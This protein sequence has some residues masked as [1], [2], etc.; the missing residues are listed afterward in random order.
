MPDAATDNLVLA[1]S[2][3]DSVGNG[4]ASGG[5]ILGPLT[6]ITQQVVVI[7]W[8]TV[9]ANT[10]RDLKWPTLLLTIFIGISIYLIRRGH[11]S[12]GADGQERKTSLL[13]FLLPKDIYTHISAPLKYSET[14]S[15]P[16]EFSPVPK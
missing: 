11:G 1:Q 14:L 6:D 13:Q 15:L 3:A 8:D 10:P 12:K 16:P 5:E 4:A 9:A 2:T 7:V